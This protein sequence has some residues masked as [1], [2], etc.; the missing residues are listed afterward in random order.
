MMNPRPSA[1]SP[2]RRLRSSHQ[3]VS[4]ASHFVAK[5]DSSSGEVVRRHL[6]GYPISLK[7]ANAKAPHVAAE[8]REHGVAVRELD[9]KGRVGQHFGH[10][11]FKLN[12]FFFRHRGIWET[13]N[14]RC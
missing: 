3:P 8:R 9:A 13:Q 6:N 4:C 10:L 7:H 2:S 1:S 14:I 11:T 12:R 5:Y